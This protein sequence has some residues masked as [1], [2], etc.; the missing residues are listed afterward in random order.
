LIGILGAASFRIKD[1]VAAVAFDANAYVEYLNNNN[2]SLNLRKYDCKEFFSMLKD[3]VLKVDR[4][5]NGF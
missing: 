1:L 5:Y 2:V 3:H 4:N